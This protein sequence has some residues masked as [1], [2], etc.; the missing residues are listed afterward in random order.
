MDTHIDASSPEAY[1]KSL[2]A[3]KV[4]L[5]PEDSKQFGDRQLR[6]GAHIH[7]S[8]IGL[9]EQSRNFLS[10]PFVQ[11]VLLLLQFEKNI[12]RRDDVSSV[13]EFCKLFPNGTKDCLCYERPPMPRSCRRAARRRF[14][15]L[16]IR[17]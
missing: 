17:D 7:H 4:K 1:Q 8:A 2:Q 3:I 16:G 15:V 6:T 5:S 10:R 13:Y 12:A 9:T 11:I 14:Q